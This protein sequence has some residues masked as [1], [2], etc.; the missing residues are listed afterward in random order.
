MFLFLLKCS[1][2]TIKTPERLKW[3]RRKYL[4]SI[5]TYFTPSSSVFIFTYEQ[6]K[7]R[8]GNCSQPMRLQDLLIINISSRN[9]QIYLIFFIKILSKKRQHLRLLLLVVWVQACVATPKL[10]QICKGSYLVVWWHCE[11]EIKVALS[12]SKKVGFICFNDS[13]S[14]IMKIAFYFT[15]NFHLFTYFLF[16]LFVFWL[17][18]LMMYEN[19]VIRKLRIISKFLRSNV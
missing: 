7:C 10:A 5:L 12:P 17:T 1:K 6:V 11:I 4:H 3:R 8:L 15:L 19:G 14:K 13:L 16:K 2:L 18:F 9:V